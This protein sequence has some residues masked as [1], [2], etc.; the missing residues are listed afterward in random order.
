MLVLKIEEEG[1]G[2]GVNVF[3]NVVTTWKIA[4]DILLDP[5]P[6]CCSITICEILALESARESDKEK[7]GGNERRS[8]R[9]QHESGTVGK[10]IG[11]CSRRKY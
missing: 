6:P 8:G 11:N 1:L 10:E 9:S 5:I 3:H 2:G 4:L 7:H